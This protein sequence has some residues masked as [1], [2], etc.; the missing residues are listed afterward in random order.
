MKRIY[1][2]FSLLLALSICFSLL[3]CSAKNKTAKKKT[4]K[5]NSSSH[6]AFSSEVESS[7]FSSEMI[8]EEPVEEDWDDSEDPEEPIDDETVENDVTVQNSAAPVTKNF[9][10][11]NAI[12]HCYTYLPDKFNR[13]YSE[14]EAD[15]EFKRI[16]Q[17]GM[18]TV[19]TYYSPSYAYNKQTNRFQWD[20]TEMKAVYKWMHKMQQCNLDISLNAAWTYHQIYEKNHWAP[21]TGLYVEGDDN[22]TAENYGNWM[23]DSLKAMKA[24][25]CNN[26]K[27]LIM[28][29]EP[30]KF[31][32]WQAST[33]KS[34]T[35]VSDPAFEGWLLF[36][37]ALDSALKK[38]GL[39]SQY[40]MVGPNDYGSLQTKEGTQTPPMFYQAVTRAND[41]IDIFSGHYYLFI[42]NVTDDTVADVADMYWKDRIN[43]VKTKTGKPFWIDEFNLKVSNKTEGTPGNYKEL[44]LQLGVALA[45]GMNHGIQNLMLWTVADQ[46]WPD[47]TTYNNDDFVNGVQRCGVLPSL[48]ESSLPRVSYY[49]TALLTKYFG[50]GSVFETVSDYHASCEQNKN[51]NYSILVVN[52]EVSSM[53]VNLNFEKSTGK[54]VYYRHCYNEDKQVTTFDAKLI[55]IDKAIQANGSGFTDV[56]P[57]RSVVIYTTEKY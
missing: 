8:D 20:S 21:L 9:M 45:Y 26:V 49:G 42:N 51:G 38:A 33:D 7:D 55:G 17:M 14:K 36:T 6:S 44:P 40:K 37:K 2:L 28:F 19:R 41:Y 4:K 18:Q 48:F 15:L 56:I 10:G 11:L 34:I 1:K 16:A 43:L 50:N 25:G 57:P 24:N 39:R 53:R 32:D 31:T 47:S 22:K 46:Q 52:S 13:N 30:N 5:N 29:T 23:V 54:K 3:G 35:E 27:Y 12:Y